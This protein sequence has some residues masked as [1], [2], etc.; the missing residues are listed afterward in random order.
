MF[1]LLPSGLTTAKLTAKLTLKGF[2]EC[3]RFLGSPFILPGQQVA[4]NLQGE[5]DVGM[6]KPF[7]DSFWVHTFFPAPQP[8][9]ILFSPGLPFFLLLKP[10]KKAITSDAYCLA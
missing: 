9:L 1:K 6:P 5:G 10:L 3:F 7:G 2:E 8:G 4:V